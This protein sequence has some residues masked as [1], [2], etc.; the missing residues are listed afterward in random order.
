MI[1]INLV[2][3]LL[4]AVHAA[5][6]KPGGVGVERDVE[7]PLVARSAV[8]VTAEAARSKARDGYLPTPTGSDDDN[9]VDEPRTPGSDVDDERAS[10]LKNKLKFRSAFLQFC[11]K[12]LKKR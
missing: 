3:G 4:A 2:A 10:M 7:L 11:F 8:G 12:I 5:P 9:F 6:T 1:G